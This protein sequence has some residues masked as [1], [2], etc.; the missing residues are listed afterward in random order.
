MHT[1]HGSPLPGQLRPLRGPARSCLQAEGEERSEDGGLQG[2]RLGP[3]PQKDSQ[4]PRASKRLCRL[5]LTALQSVFVDL[6]TNHI[7]IVYFSKSIIH[8]LCFL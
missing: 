1:G 7:H 6:F 8:N 5:C 4:P 3:V 2:P